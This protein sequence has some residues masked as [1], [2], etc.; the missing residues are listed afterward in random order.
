MDL[1]QKLI[2][3]KIADIMGVNYFPILRRLKELE[4]FEMRPIENYLR[5]F[6][7]GGDTLS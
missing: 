7:N 4:L 3:K 2:V 1:E 6:K 5:T